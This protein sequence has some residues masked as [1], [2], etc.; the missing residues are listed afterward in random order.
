MPYRHHHTHQGLPL[1]GRQRVEHHV[2]FLVL[3]VKVPPGYLGKDLR[4]KLPGGNQAIPLSV[5]KKNLPI[6]SG[7]HAV[8]MVKILLGEGRS[9]L[10]ILGIFHEI[11]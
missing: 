4:K 1:L 11:L 5:G 8:L 10:R 7:H 2:S 6:P 3:R 9:L